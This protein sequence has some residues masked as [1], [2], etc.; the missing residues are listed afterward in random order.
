MSA[1]AGAAIARN[2]EQGS[3]SEETLG[4]RSG[5]LSEGGG[6][7]GVWI[8]SE[9][10]KQDG[11]EREYGRAGGGSAPVTPRSATSGP[12][13]SEPATIPDEREPAA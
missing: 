11:G 6:G 7:E 1:W 9:A 2:D 8:S 5:L 4:M 10:A 13:I 3:G 12:A